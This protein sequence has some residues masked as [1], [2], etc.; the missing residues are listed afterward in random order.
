MNVTLDVWPFCLYCPSTGIK[1]SL[2]LRTKPKAFCILSEL[3]QLS[4][5]TQDS[6]SCKWN[7]GTSPGW[8]TGEFVGVLL[9]GHLGHFL[10]FWNMSSDLL[11]LEP[12]VVSGVRE[13][14]GVCRFGPW[15]R[16]CYQMAVGH[17]LCKGDA[18]SPHQ[19]L[20]H[21]DTRDSQWWRNDTRNS[22]LRGKEKI[23]LNF[24]NSHFIN[25]K[26]KILN[27]ELV[28]WPHSTASKGARP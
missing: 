1:G 19:S 7:W 11:I 23:V 4:H 17:S 9:W 18:R 21:W 13:R 15:T 20:G 22:S 8:L 3:C 14:P 5:R 12:V 6:Y 2:V 28:G 10:V 27:W 24:L 26:E 25:A 16:T